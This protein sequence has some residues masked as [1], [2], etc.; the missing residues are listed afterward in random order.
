[1]PFETVTYLLPV[2]DDCGQ[3]PSDFDMDDEQFTSRPAAVELLGR[4][5]WEFTSR[6]PNL[7]GVVTCPDCRSDAPQVDVPSEASAFFAGYAEGL[8]NGRSWAAEAGEK[9]DG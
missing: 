8:G 6:G 1:M 4:F 2:C 7:P 9:T 5:G 3:T